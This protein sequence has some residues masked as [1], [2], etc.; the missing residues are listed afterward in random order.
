MAMKKN[1]MGLILASTMAAST[2][3]AS[4]AWA[5]GPQVRMVTQVSDGD[6]KKWNLA[7]INARNVFNDLGKDNV[8]TEIIA[9]GPSIDML[10]M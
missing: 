3:A 2:M 5:A 8:Q 6:P 1:L 10:K 9:Y 7:L 4:S